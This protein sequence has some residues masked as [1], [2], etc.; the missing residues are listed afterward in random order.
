VTAS[1]ASVH[2]TRLFGAGIE[3]CRLFCVLSY[4]K[5]KGGCSGNAKLPPSFFLRLILATRELHLDSRPVSIGVNPRLT[6][7]CFSGVL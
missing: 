6:F 3:R 1:E 5:G 2:R 4:A 7:V